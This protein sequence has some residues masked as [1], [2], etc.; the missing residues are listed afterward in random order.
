ML[1]AFRSLFAPPPKTPDQLLC[2]AENIIEQRKFGLTMHVKSMRQ[3][4]RSEYK[5]AEEAIERDG[6]AE[7]CR[8][9]NYLAAVAKQAMRDA[10]RE[11]RDIDA[12]AAMI[13]AQRIKIGKISVVNAMNLAM[14]T[15]LSV[16]D[17]QSADKSVAKMQE[18]MARTEVVNESLSQSLDPMGTLADEAQKEADNMTDAML[19]RFNA[20]AEGLPRVPNM[21]EKLTEDAAALGPL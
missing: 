17:R 16:S 9:H 8:H 6:D 18:L 10:Q 21:P 15:V 1:S 4:H 20:R 3:K 12:L 19:R 13:P 2:D 14:Q 11:T 7:A 5:Q